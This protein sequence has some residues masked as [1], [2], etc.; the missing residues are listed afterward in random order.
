MTKRKPTPS[1]AEVVRDLAA[2]PDRPRDGRRAIRPGTFNLDGEFF[3]PD[4]TPLECPGEYLCPDDALTELCNGALLAF[5]GCGC[6][7]RGGCAPD[8]LDSRQRRELGR[9]GRRL[10]T[11]GCWIELWIGGRIRVVF[12]HGPIRWGPHLD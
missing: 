7:G 6:G 2:A 12:A 4:G 8:W 11:N 5:E 3:A 1:L 9:A 10:L